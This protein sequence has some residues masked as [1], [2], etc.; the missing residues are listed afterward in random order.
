MSHQM[1][2]SNGTQRA[3]LTAWQ[4]VALVS[5][6]LCGLV[7]YVLLPSPTFGVLTIARLFSIVLVAASALHVVSRMLQAPY[8]VRIATCCVLPAIAFSLY[9]WIFPAI[10]PVLH[11]TVYEPTYLEL[12]VPLVILFLV[13]HFLVEMVLLASAPVTRSKK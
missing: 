11:R 7:A 1:T 8:Q 5:F 6:A 3:G 12:F 2:K 9:G 13:A 4:V 10:D